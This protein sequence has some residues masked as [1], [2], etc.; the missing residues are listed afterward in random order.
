MNEVSGTNTVITVADRSVKAI[1]A[2]TAGLSK[3]V[4]EVLALTATLENLSG[5]IQQ[6]ESQLADLTRQLD[7]NARNAKAELAVRVAEA[8]TEVLHVL[9]AKNKLAKVTTDELQKLVDDLQTAKNTAAESIATAVKNAESALHAQYGSKL[10]SQEADFK[11]ANAELVAD[12][13]AVKERNQFLTDELVKARQDLTAERDA[14]IQ[15]AK[16]EAGRQGVVVN[17]GKQ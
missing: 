11:V 10:R 8:E 12:L 15:I 9:L 7:L 16:A 13:R 3:V 1:G 17:A 14:R 6:K 2:A 4:A 5:D